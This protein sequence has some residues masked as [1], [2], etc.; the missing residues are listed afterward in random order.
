M[1]EMK[2]HALMVYLFVAW[3]ANAKYIGWD[4]IGGISTRGKQGALA[5]AVTYLP[6]RK[7]L[8]DEFRQWAAD[9][10]AQGLLAHYESTI[11]VS[12]FN[13][14]VCASCFQQTGIQTRTRVNGITYDTFQCKNCGRS[15]QKN[16][17][18]DRH[19]NSARVSALLLQH[20][21]HAH[22]GSTSCR[23]ITA[24]FL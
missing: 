15:S 8:Y 18:L 14:H 6:K 1:K 3:K 16:M 11:P 7:G 23:I 9:L 24:R 17:N 21:V 12:P 19:S 20:H 13:S 22:H 2:R 10:K 4:S 5:Q